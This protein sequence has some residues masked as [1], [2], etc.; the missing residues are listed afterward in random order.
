M[1]ENEY[2]I[3]FATMRVQMQK[4]FFTKYVTPGLRS[5]IRKSTCSFTYSF[6]PVLHAVAVSSFFKV[7]FMQLNSC[8]WIMQLQFL[9]SWIIHSAVELCSSLKLNYAVSLKLNYSKFW[10]R[11]MNFHQPIFAFSFTLTSLYLRY[12]LR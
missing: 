6:T 2:L 8:S 1:R 3:I 5:V 9:Y 12:I 11:Y 4:E 10:K 7:W